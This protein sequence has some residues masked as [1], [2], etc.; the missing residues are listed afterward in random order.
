MSESPDDRELSNGTPPASLLHHLL[1]ITVFALLTLLVTRPLLAHL[2]DGVLGAGAADNMSSLWNIWWARTAIHGPGSLFST[3]ALFAPFGTSLA[4]HSL[5]P[6][7]SVAAA[8]LPV[9]P[10]T[11]YNTALLASV[12]LNFI[13]G[14]AAG[15]M[16]TRDWRGALFAGVTF[17]ASP[18]LLVRLQGHLNVLSAWGLPLLLVA[19]IRYERT[20]EWTSAIMVGGALG[21]LGYTDYYFAIFGVVILV[22]HLMLARWT[23]A[24][25]SKADGA[26]GAAQRASRVIIALIVIDLVLITW[27]Q[28]TGGTDITV[29]GIRLRMTDSFNPRVALGFLLVA[30]AIVWRR[31]VVTCSAA[32]TPPP[33]DVWRFLPVV[34][35]TT[36]LLIVPLA[37]A[38]WRLWLDGDYQ[39]QVYFWRS[40]P[41]GID[42]ATLL[43]G[44]PLSPITG[45][46][47]ASVLEH[48]HIDRIEST[49][50]IGIVPLLL[51]V[52]AIRRLRFRADVQ[53]DLWI[54][55]LFLVWSL[56]PYLRVLGHNTGFML[57]QT[58]LHFVP[59]VANAR[60]PGRAFV[61][62]QL[63][64]AIIGAR[65]LLSLKVADVVTTG[66]VAL[67]AALVV[68]DY[69][70]AAQPWIG[71]DHPGV[72]DTLRD[73][74]AG[75]VLEVP[76]GLRDGFGDR[77]RLD[78]RVLF[79]QTIHEHP[80]IGGF[81]ARLSS[82]IR[83]AY[84]SDPVIRT[85]LDLSEDK[86]ASLSVSPASPAQ[87]VSCDVSYVVID[88][89]SA[90][91]EL[92]AFVAKSFELRPLARSGTRALY[93]VQ[94]R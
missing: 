66:I 81:V 21:L 6:L 59:I 45:S 2:S 13:C 84:E 80:L 70:P 88:E 68:A 65:A 63:M 23:P 17:G 90:S 55:G 72:Y 50:W 19:V 25:V 32:E 89:A 39:S 30:A 47:T 20:P 22:A 12:F 28:I 31:P 58:F 48:S 16:V 43:L 74:P 61:V 33:S 75:A 11:A 26:G 86:P 60:I 41:P 46:W 18:F 82:R 93:S 77:G 91:S 67:S 53:R 71:V 40:A 35:A 38:A 14:Y 29:A 79:Y 69:L 54:G 37:A 56:G 5:A 7:E 85:I 49:A 44:N 76:L 42:V 83:L 92:Q 64:I 62:V 51:V 52:L 87:C 36:L 9:P 27:I 10:L 4:L 57:P 3:S 1:A 15:W 24:V 8:R 94:S 34:A 73:Q 78:H